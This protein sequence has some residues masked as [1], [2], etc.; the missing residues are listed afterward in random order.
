MVIPSL[1]LDPDGFVS[2]FDDDD[3]E[4]EG[5]AFIVAALPKLCPGVHSLAFVDSFPIES[6]MSSIKAEI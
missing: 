1:T 3:C 4:W 2:V 5:F 6:V